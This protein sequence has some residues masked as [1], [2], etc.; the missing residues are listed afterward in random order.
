MAYPPRSTRALA[1]TLVVL[2]H[3]SGLYAF[4]RMDWEPALVAGAPLQVALITPEAPSP[5]VEAPPAPPEPLP[6]EPAPP[7]KPVPPKPRPKPEPKPRPPEPVVTESPTAITA[8]VD[9]EPAPA[10]SAPAAPAESISAAPAPVVRGNPGPAEPVVTEARFDADYLNNPPPVYPPLSRRMRE[11][12]R[13]MLRVHVSADGSPT[14]VELNT[15][16][17]SGRLDNA[18]RDAVQRWRFAP[19]RRGD[20]AVDA[21]VLVPIV[22]KLEGS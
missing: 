12:G 15:S 1:F 20:R 22:F 6:V 4:T 3:A 11:E 13:V 16:S 7:P 17:G 21:W 9:P 2:A 10:E 18:A 14:A 8:A 19:A 5:V